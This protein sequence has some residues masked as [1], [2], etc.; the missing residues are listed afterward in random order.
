[1]STIWPPG[2]PSLCHYR[3]PSPALVKCRLM[4]ASLD[5]GAQSKR[6]EGWTT[7][8]VGLCDL[9]S[10]VNSLKAAQGRAPV[11]NMSSNTP[12]SQT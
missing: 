9:H 7:V 10:Q 11:N 3:S 8:Y 12:A 2:G 4:V 6:C 5:K 1:M